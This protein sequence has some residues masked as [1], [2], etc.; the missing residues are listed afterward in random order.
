MID[1][2]NQSKNFRN[3]KWQHFNFEEFWLTVN[4]AVTCCVRASSASVPFQGFLRII[5]ILVLTR[6]QLG[7][8]NPTIYS[9]VSKMIISS[10][11]KQIPGFKISVEQMKDWGN[12]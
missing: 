9:E 8:K 3:S 5:E 2:Q 11:F 10:K 12:K 7:L 1:D 4:A 6:S